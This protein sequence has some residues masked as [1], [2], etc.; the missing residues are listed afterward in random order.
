MTSRVVD[1]HLEKERVYD[2][3][4][5]YVSENPVS[6]VV[7]DAEA[8]Q[9]VRRQVTVLYSDIRD[10]TR[11]SYKADPAAVVAYLNA[12]FSLIC[13]IVVKHGGIVDKFT[14]DGC[15]ALFGALEARSEHALRAAR[16]ALEMVQVAGEIT[17]PD[18]EPT[19]VGVGL[20][21][22]EVVVGSIGAPGR[23]DYTAIGDTVNLAARI[24]GMTRQLEKDIVVTGAVVGAA[25]G[26][27]ITSKLGTF[28]IRGREGRIGLHELTGV[29]GV[30]DTFTG[31]RRPQL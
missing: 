10:F 28:E 1:Q 27:L 30:T 19:R 2:R 21:T 17:R 18:E 15:L 11:L 13:D 8:G 5:E 9:G 20:A 6:L 16:A 31:L 23:R 26:C 4:G 7:G 12:Y 24:E 29:R 3:F 22:G 25:N 14:G